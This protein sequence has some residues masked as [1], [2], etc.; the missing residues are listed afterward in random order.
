MSRETTGSGRIKKYG[1]CL[2]DKCEHY[3]EI[4]EVLHGEMVCEC[5][6]KLS[7]CGPPKKK[8][9]KL[10][11]IIGAA[12]V[13]IAVIVGLILAFS[14]NSNEPETAGVD[15]T[16]VDSIAVA[17]KADTVTIVKTDTVKQ[18]DTVTIEKTIE[19][20]ETPKATK[21]TTTT[22]K[23]SK[24]SDARKGTV[25]LSYGTY[26]GDTKN[27]F[28]DGMGRLTYSTSRKINRYD[29]KGRMASAGD[30]VIGEFVRGF[31]IQGKHYSSNGELIET[32]MIGTPAT[33]AY[34]S[35]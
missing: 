11:L 32:I 30:Y 15:T 20:V 34:E 33:S 7:P 17:P 16:K 31:F 18:I 8:S 14:G 12:V 28:P 35:K 3:K 13:V 10:P 26:K 5:G 25:R 21:T 27:G 2:N 24:S 4:Q 6:K 9:S 22:T 29:S 1:V 19:K 23:T